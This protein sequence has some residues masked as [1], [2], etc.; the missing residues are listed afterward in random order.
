MGFLDGS[1]HQKDP[2][3]IRSLDLSDLVSSVF[4]RGERA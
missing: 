1:Y 3:V 2:A 4:R